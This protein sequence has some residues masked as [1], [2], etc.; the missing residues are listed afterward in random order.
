V[1]GLEQARDQGKG[2]STH[3]QA[4]DSAGGNQTETSTEEVTERVGKQSTEEGS[5][6]QDRNDERLIPGGKVWR[7]RR[8]G[9]PNRNGV[10]NAKRPG[11]GNIGTNNCQQ[12]RCWE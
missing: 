12:D 8:K 5:G 9:R 3:S 4:E 1:S 6:G 11:R 10:R 2:N 7:E